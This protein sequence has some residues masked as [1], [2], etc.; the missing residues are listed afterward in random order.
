MVRAF[1]W[2]VLLI[3]TP[4]SAAE[5]TIPVP[6]FQLIRVAGPYAVHLTTA[7]APAAR[8]AG[9]TDAVDALDLHVEGGTLIVRPRGG[10]YALKAGQPVPTITLATGA[11]RSIALSGGGEL[12]VDGALAGDRIDLNVTGRGTLAAPAMRADQLTVT[13]IGAG[14]IT[15][16]GTARG[17]RLTANGG[18]RIAAAGLIVD[19]LIVHSEGLT[20]VTVTARYTALASATG[21]G[22]IRILGQPECK[23][24]E[25]LR[26]TIDCYRPEPY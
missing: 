14:D 16:G 21:A 10:L 26:G 8:V 17:V 9:D 5:R 11:V 13:L 18:G 3:A 6:D 12:T 2:L 24:R 15:L 19:D 25:V 23:R 20:E 1:P 22:P 4:A 7:A